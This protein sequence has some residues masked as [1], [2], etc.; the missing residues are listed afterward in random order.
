M[1]VVEQGRAQQLLE[2]AVR[3]RLRGSIVEEVRFSIGNDSNG[4]PAV[5][6]WLV[7]PDDA[8]NDPGGSGLSSLAQTVESVVRDHGDFW[9][10]VYFQSVSE[11]RAPER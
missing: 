8:A 5:W 6:I 10:Y 9:P 3:D 4:V 11:Q 7:V 1:A 2:D